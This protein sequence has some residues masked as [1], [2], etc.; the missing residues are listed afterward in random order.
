MDGISFHILFL[1]GQIYL[2]KTQVSPTVQVMH[3]HRHSF[4]HVVIQ[5]FQEKLFLDVPQ[6]GLWCRKA[7]TVQFPGHTCACNGRWHNHPWINKCLM[8]HSA[9]NEGI[10]GSL[11]GRTSLHTLKYIHCCS[12]HTCHCQLRSRAWSCKWKQ[13]GK[14]QCR[15]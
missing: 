9:P 12:L 2:Q 10:S 3:R 7:D 6:R 4:W 15:K 1:K 5:W 11:P 14:R 13:P 8:A